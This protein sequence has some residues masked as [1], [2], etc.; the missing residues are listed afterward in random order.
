MK[1]E[2]QTEEY[3]EHVRVQSLLTRLSK[4]C[5]LTLRDDEFD[6]SW[7]LDLV[8]SCRREGCRFRLI[9]SGALDA[10]E[11]EWLGKAGA[12]VYSSDEAGRK[13]GELELVNLACRRGGALSSFLLRSPLRCEE[14]R[15]FLFSDM[16][17]LGLS[18]V[19]LFLSSS[20]AAYDFSALSELAF[21]CRRGGSWLVYYHHRSP[22]EGLELLA[23][24]GA[25]I[26]LADRYFQGSSD[27]E[28]LKEIVRGSGKGRNHFI[29]HIEKKWQTVYIEALVEADAFLLFMPALSDYRS[30][31]RPLEE[32]AMKKSLDFR[33]FYL[34]PDVFI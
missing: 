33:T 17:N 11:L 20:E 27:L 14:E 12:D 10:S 6:F 19:Y 1:E 15:E 5:D 18:G 4:G 8:R 25:W 7:L 34:Y 31:L 3:S 30:P 28:A 32:R 26:H 23:R 9:D 2:G 29:I 21:S 24:S 16:I 13:P 22:E